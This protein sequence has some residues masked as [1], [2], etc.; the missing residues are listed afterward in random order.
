MDLKAFAGMM[1]ELPNQESTMPVMF[2]GHGSPMNA[3]EDNE[4]T[5]GWK[6]AAAKLPVPKAILCVSAHWE[7]KGTQVTAMKMPPTI[8]DFGGFPEKLFQQ[9]YPAPGSPDLAGEIKH[10]VKKTEIALD[11]KW[12]LDHGTWSVLLPMFPKADIPVLQLSIDYTKD[13]KYHF[14]LAKELAALRKKGVLIV[15]SGNIVH[16]LGMM[17]WKDGAYDWTI[18]FDTKIKEAILKE[19]WESLINY[20]K[21]GRA[22]DL[23]VP[24]NEHYLPLLYIAALKDSKD[25][26]TFFN[27]KNTMGSISMRSVVFH[28]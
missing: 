14:E 6:A 17:Q 26:T 23:S 22:A 27:E 18:E 2:A 9:Q 16:N 13:A 24:S 10:L 11:E 3:I 15:G 7:T 25:K 28:G 12:G 19:D 1:S 21:F 4:F 20:R 5:R 8:H